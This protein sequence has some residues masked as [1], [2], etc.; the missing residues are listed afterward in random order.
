L[1]PRSGA[2]RWPA[3]AALSRC[4]FSCGWWAC[5]AAWTGAASARCGASGNAWAGGVSS[6]PA[7]RRLA[8]TAGVACA[9]WRGACPAG[10]LGEPAAASSRWRSRSGR[11]ARWP[12]SS[13]RDAAAR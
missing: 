5:P 10:P 4:R 1:P 3:S 9:A 7:A 11:V 13:S 6:G 2:G 8:W 12:V